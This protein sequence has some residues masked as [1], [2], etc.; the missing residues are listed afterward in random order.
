MAS[1]P[2]ALGLSALLFIGSVGTSRAQSDDKD[3]SDF[4]TWQEARA[5]YEANR[6]GDPHGLDAD[7]DGVA[8]ETM[9]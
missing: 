6:P 4:S 3:C 8:C 5:F 1:R 2:I 7:N 9:R